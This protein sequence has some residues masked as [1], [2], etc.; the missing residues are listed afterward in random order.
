MHSLQHGH[1]PPHTTYAP[2]PH[3][4]QQSHVKSEPVDSRYVLSNPPSMAQ[5]GIPTLPGPQIPGRPVA[6]AQQLP[7]YPLVNGARPASAAGQQ[8]PPPPTA[9]YPPP[10]APPAPTARIPQV[11]GPSALASTSRIPQVDGPSSSSSESP[12]PPPSQNNY[13]PRS[14]HPSLP[15]PAPNPSTTKVDDSEAINSELDDSDSDNEQEGIE[16]GTA[17]T[18]IVFC[19]YDKVRVGFS[20]STQ[21]P[22]EDTP[23]CPC[24]EQ[25]EVRPQ[26]WHDSYQ[27]EGL[28]LRQVHG[29]RT[30]LSPVLVPLSSTHAHTASLSGSGTH[31]LPN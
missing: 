30:Y 4:M 20:S 14:S 5:Y 16:G 1:Y 17:D 25:V 19:T 7:S 23:G 31:G 6:P 13:A 10:A 3:S 27:R 11:D 2:P 21:I 18:D 29:V 12:S 8:P 26:R 9:R 22:T 28:P 24:E 15:Q